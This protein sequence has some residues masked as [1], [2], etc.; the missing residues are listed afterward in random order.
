MCEVGPIFTNVIQK[1]GFIH[2]DEFG[3][4]IQ[5]FVLVKK[6]FVCLFVCFTF[7]NYHFIVDILFRPHLTSCLCSDTLSTNETVPALLRLGRKL[8]ME[9]RTGVWLV[10][11][12]P[13]RCWQLL[14]M[15][16]H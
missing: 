11:R 9:L 3:L 5:L 8:G 12:L 6:R 4:I 2:S 7:I 16:T 13:N 10:Q 14:L 15:E 1:V